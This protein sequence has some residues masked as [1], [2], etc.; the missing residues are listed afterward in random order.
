MV[1]NSKTFT[2]EEVAKHN[3]KK[4]CWIIVHGKV[5]DVTPFLDDHPGGDESL[6]SA[7]EKDATIDFED[8]GHSDSAKELMQ[9]YYVGEVDDTTLP[10]KVNQSQ[11]RPPTQAHADSNQ[12]SGFVVKILQFFLPLLMLGF[13]FA[14]QYYKKQK[15][16]VSDS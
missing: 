10:A 9:K 5:Y 4:D 7:A 15:K 12:S 8:V 11:P 14:L 2:F 6:L 16:Q 3:H 13:A 1:S